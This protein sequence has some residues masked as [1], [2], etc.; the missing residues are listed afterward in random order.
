MSQYTA[1][2][3][4]TLGCHGDGKK[5][6]RR[7]CDELRLRNYFVVFIKMPAAMDPKVNNEEGATATFRVKSGLAQ[8]LKGE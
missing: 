8:M 6:G 3:T 7:G 1:Y 4:K 5:A 2:S